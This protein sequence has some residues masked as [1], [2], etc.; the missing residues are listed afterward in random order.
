VTAFAAEVDRP[1]RTHGNL[2][3]FPQRPHR[4]V[5]RGK[6]VLETGRHAR[7]RQEFRAEQSSRG[8][9]TDVPVR[10]I[11]HEL[12][13]NPIQIRLNVLHSPLPTTTATAPTD[14]SGAAP[15]HKKR[16]PPFTIAIPSVSLHPLRLGDMT[17]KVKM[18]QSMVSTEIWWTI[19]DTLPARAGPLL[20]EVERR[21]RR[22]LVGKL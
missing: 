17:T 18:I 7:R 10:V 1:R 9:R 4:C 8:R 3:S 5:V 16:R 14:E 6:A 20:G 11:V 2:P 19:R 22:R 21:I 13:Y 12:K 15:Q